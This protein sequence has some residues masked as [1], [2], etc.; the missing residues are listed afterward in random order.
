M[1][2]RAALAAWLC[3]LLAAL[4]ATAATGEVAVAPSQKEA[5]E[6]K[7]EVVELTVSA[8]REERSLF[9]APHALAR[10]LKTSSSILG[11]QL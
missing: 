3:L 7:A 9:R 11:R 10:A 4:A 2:Q 5:A 8:R 6:R 1:L